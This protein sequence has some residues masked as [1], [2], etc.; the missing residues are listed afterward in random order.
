VTEHGL[1][2]GQRDNTED[3]K[4]LPFFAGVTVVFDINIEI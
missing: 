1:I 3:D 2:V 4:T